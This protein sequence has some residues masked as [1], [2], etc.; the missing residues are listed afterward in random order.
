[1]AKF[2]DDFSH[3]LL[4]E[5]NAKNMHDLMLLKQ[6]E[7]LTSLLD[8]DDDYKKPLSIGQRSY[9]LIIERMQLEVT[10]MRRY[11]NANPDIITQLNKE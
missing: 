2:D 6:H 4:K 9:D 7:F 5:C 3:W 11:Y 10:A 8:I 1:M